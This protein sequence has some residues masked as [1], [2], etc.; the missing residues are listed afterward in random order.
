MVIIGDRPTITI[1]NSCLLLILPHY[2]KIVDFATFFQNKIDFSS[3]L[4]FL[5]LNR[6]IKEKSTLPAFI[7][8]LKNQGNVK[9]WQLKQ[10]EA[11]PLC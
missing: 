10:A 11:P 2:H 6:N 7:E 1:R 9:N 8:Q 4:S 3:L 5:N